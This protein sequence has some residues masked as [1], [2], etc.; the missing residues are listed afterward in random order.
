MDRSVEVRVNVADM[1]RLIADSDLAIGASG[2]TA[3]ERCCLGVPTLM[4]VLAENQQDIA[5]ALSCAD[6]ALV[7]DDVEQL[8]EMLKIP[9]EKLKQMSCAASRITDGLGS[10]L[11]IQHLKRV[12]KHA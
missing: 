1:A 9:K 11:T 12:E 3:W 7:F 5:A 10:Q 6:A 8:K 4:T 2:G